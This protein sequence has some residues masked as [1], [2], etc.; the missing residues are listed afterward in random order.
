MHPHI[1]R[2]L[3][4]LTAI[5][6]ALEQD[7]SVVGMCRG[8][9]L[10]NILFGGALHQNLEGDRV[11]ADHRERHPITAGSGSLA[12]RVVGARSGASSSHHRAVSR[13]GRGLRAVA[14]S[15][16]DVN[17]AVEV[18]RGRFALGVQ[19]HPEERQN[20]GDR[21][22]ATPLVDAAVAHAA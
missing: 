19:F 4:D 13:I 7:I 15:D 5:Q 16:D 14:V 8:H 17:E 22:L 11:A 2:D 1:E 3:Q 9:Q 21:R 12:R 10:L 18:P 6:V 20:D